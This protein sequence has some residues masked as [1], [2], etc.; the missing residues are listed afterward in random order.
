MNKNDKFLYNIDDVV[1][2]KFLILEREHK[3]L[4]PSSKYKTRTYRCKCLCDGY[5]F[6]SSESNLKCMKKCAVCLGKV[7][8]KG[9]NDIATKRPEIVRFLKYN[10]QKLTYKNNKSI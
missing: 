8:I 2:G 4:F 10:L 9:I 3:K 5:I 7:V 1:N 6:E